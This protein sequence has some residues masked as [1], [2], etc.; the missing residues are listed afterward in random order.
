MK[1]LFETDRVQAELSY[2]EKKMTAW[3][4]AVELAAYKERH[5]DSKMKRS[6]HNNATPGTVLM[7]CLSYWF[8]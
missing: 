1:L 4:A 5:I 7:T 3:L 2:F 6:A 8:T